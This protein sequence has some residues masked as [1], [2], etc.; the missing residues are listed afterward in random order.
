MDISSH[1]HGG[2]C[3]ESRPGPCAFVI[4]GA[5]GDLAGRKL[6]PGLFGLYRRGLLKNFFVLGCGRKRLDDD[7]FRNMVR[8]SLSLHCPGEQGQDD[9]IGRMFYVSGEY[10]S[11]GLCDAVSLRRAEL[12][13]R[14]STGGNTIY[15]MATPPF[16]FRQIAAGLKACGVGKDREGGPFSRLVVEKPYGRDRKDAL[17][18]DAE[19]KEF[20]A[21]NQ[22]YRIDHYLGK[23]TVQNIALLRFANTL[24]EPLWNARYIDNV[25]L[26]VA[27]TLGIEKRAGFFEHTGTMLDMFQNH[28]LRLL[29]LITMERPSVL[30]A[31]G[32]RNERLNMYRAL[33]AMTPADISANVIRGQ[34][35]AGGGMI[36]YREEE[37]VS[38]DSQM[39]TFV[40]AKLLI[41]ND[42]WRGVPFYLRTGKRLARHATR[43]VITFKRVDSS[44]FPMY[45][46]SDIEPNTLVLDIQPEESVS[47]AVQTKLPGPRFCLTSRQLKFDYAGGGPDAPDAYERLLLDCAVG[48]QMLFVRH[49]NMAA[50]WD[51]VTPVLEQWRGNAAASKLHMYE[52]GGWGPEAAR[53]LPERDGR[54]WHDFG[55]AQ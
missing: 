40:A 12:D 37:G 24:F 7:S 53:L 45:A 43:A 14:F 17:T 3:M 46:P 48:D 33:S 25:Q 39:E 52:A 55:A 47:I 2:L 50:A 13:A 15:Y 31:D 26:T 42:R 18:L 19:L 36:G 34:Y 49:D 1:M 38:P 4:F 8:E 6:L 21:E 11:Y 20:L 29:S 54:K 9:F 5:S 27:E 10:G 30:D 35:S 51:W 28:M 23:E 22:I 32:L 16:L 44:V 41:N